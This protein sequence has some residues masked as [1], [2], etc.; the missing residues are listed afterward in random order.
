MRADRDRVVGTCFWTA[1]GIVLALISAPPPATAQ[2]SAEEEQRCVWQCLANSPGA[3]SDEYNQCVE[4]RCVEQPRAAPPAASP[5]PRA[6]WTFGPGKGG[7]HYAGV[8]IPG[9]S[10]SYL[11]K[12]GGPGLLAIAGLSRR[13]DAI[14][15]R[16]DG[17]NYGL[18]FV[19]QNGVLY[20]DAPAGS[21][22]LRALLGGKAVHVTDA[23]SGASASFPLSGSGAAIRKALA[24]CGLPS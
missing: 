18:T 2:M 9:K 20:T 24:G 23:T 6:A 7:S 10:F 22:L 15:L 4:E 14:S 11:C 3:A 5:A 17:Q 1:A 19:A 21:H 8:E 13:A 16:V 12:R